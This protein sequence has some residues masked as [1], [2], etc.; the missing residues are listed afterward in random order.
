MRDDIPYR[1]MFLFA[2]LATILTFW[3]CDEEKTEVQTEKVF[4]DLIVETV[5]GNGKIYPVTEVKISARVQGKIIE[6]SVD[7][8]D[9][10]K[11]DQVL[12]KLEREQYQAML[13]RAQSAQL[14]TRAN[15]KLA[16]QELKRQQDLFEQ[17]LVAK[18][19]LEIA[20][21]Q[22]D[23]SL[24]Q[25]RQAQAGVREAKDALERTVISSP[26]DGIVIQKN[27]EKGEIALGSQFQEDVILVVAQL[28]EMEVRIDVNEN[29]IVK[30]SKN[31]TA[32]VEIDAFPDTTFRAVVTDISNS[33]QV[34][35]AGTIEEV[36]NFEVRV[37]LLDRLPTF[38]PGMSATADVA[39]E[40]RQ[41]ALNLPI[42]SVTV[43]EQSTLKEERK[44]E[45]A[46]ASESDSSSEVTENRKSKKQAQMTEVVFVVNNGTVSMRPVT[47]GISDDAYYEVLG[48]LS[49]GDEVVTGPYR[50]LSRDLKDGQEIKVNN[51]SAAGKG[52]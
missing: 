22:R 30:I 15:L 9:S 10:V 42:Q 24:G 12:L 23:R 4:R 19:E 33:A 17:R 39:T 16:E 31:D 20:E 21:A 18:S 3:G 5:T 45:A 27:K 50:T 29:D 52:D 11:A 34:K 13:E 43:R 8:G 51:G 40:T 32:A 1:Q 36:T 41:E 37:R 48:G 47:L 6:L 14:E 28:S 49:A 25:L 46:R 35:G 26:I 2:L 38:R 7:Q 44:G